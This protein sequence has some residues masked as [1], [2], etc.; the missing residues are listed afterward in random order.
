MKWNFPKE[1]FKGTELRTFESAPAAADTLDEL[2]NEPEPQDLVSETNEL[3]S[4]TVTEAPSQG[5]TKV[6]PPAAPVEAPQLRRS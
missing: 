4:Q 2:R 1:F 5:V 6:H 3:P